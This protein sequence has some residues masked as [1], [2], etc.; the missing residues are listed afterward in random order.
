MSEWKVNEMDG[1][2]I[3][4]KISEGNIIFKDI[5]IGSL[6]YFLKDVFD[7]NEFVLDIERHVCLY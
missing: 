4:Y 3:E 2:F 7:F 6:F 1:E 5:I